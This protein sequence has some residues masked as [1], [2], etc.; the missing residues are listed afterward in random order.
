[1]LFLD[2][3]CVLTF[4]LDPVKIECTEDGQ[5]LYYGGE[6]LGVVSRKNKWLINEG[7]AKQQ[8]KN[9]IFTYFLIFL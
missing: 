1:M 5:N 9:P 7:I 6:Q 8:S 4:V 2:R 3:G